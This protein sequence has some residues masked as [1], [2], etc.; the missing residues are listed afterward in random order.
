MLPPAIPN[1]GSGTRL[2]PLSRRNLPKQ[3][4]GLTGVQQTV[5]RTLEGAARASRY[6]AT[7]TASRWRR[8]RACR[9]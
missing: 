9:T 4:L 2:W 1:D 3:L 8:A 7:I 5:T 6:A